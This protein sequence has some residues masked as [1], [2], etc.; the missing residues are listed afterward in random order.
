[1]TDG[2]AKEWLH[3]VAVVEHGAIDDAL[4]ILGVLLEV[5]VMGGDDAER[6]VT[7]EALE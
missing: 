6:A 4:V 2:E 7:V 5:L 1:M 3:E